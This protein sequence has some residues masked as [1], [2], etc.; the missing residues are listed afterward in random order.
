MKT[1][2]LVLL[3]L[4][5]AVNTSHALN[6]MTLVGQYEGEDPDDCFG[7]AMTMGDFDDDGY[8]EFII[9]AGGWNGYM[10]K[11]Y[12]YD[13]NGDWPTAPAWTFQGSA[14]HSE[15]DYDD[16]NVGDINGDG[17]D[18]FA[19]T[20]WIWQGARGVHFFY[21]GAD[22][23]SLPD[24]SMWSGDAPGLFG[25]LIDSCGDVNGDGGMDFIF[26][27]DWGG[28]NWDT[29]I[30]F[31]GQALDTIPDWI[32]P[33]TY[34]FPSGLGDVNGDG[35]ADIL[36]TGMNDEPPKLFF[37]GSPMDTI[38]DLIFPGIT[39]MEGSGVGDINGDDYNDFCISIWFPDSADGY[40]ELFFGGS[41]LDNIPEVI[42]QNRFGEPSGALFSLSCGD[43]N[44]DGYNDIVSA[45]GDQVFGVVVYIYLGS[46]SFNPVPDALVTDW[47]TFQGFG[48][49]VASGDVNGDSCDE[50]LVGAPQWPYYYDN[51]I[52]YLYT[53]PEEW[54]DYGAIVEPEE[55]VKYSG[56]FKLEQNFPNPFNSATSI[57]FE[58]GKASA[59]NLRI[60]DIAGDRIKN[61]IVNQNMLPGGYNVS[62][63]GKN[64]YD[65]PVASG[66]YLLELRVDSYHQITKMIV[67]R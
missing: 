1:L 32:Y 36:I 8:D 34:I 4:S 59:V 47:S 49:A 42:L 53:G 52:A 27:V 16:Q 67:L 17:L 15:Y 20:E 54:I 38:P 21:G 2:L 19:L 33:S 12:F 3:A 39:F 18:D 23:D 51:G 28:I 5:L 25:H 48:E 46:P 44:G 7:G 45:T 63:T 61:L 22:F 66:V 11:N 24:W 14:A 55:L 50:L 35:Y 37:G 41:D 31:G 43:F 60:Y 40:N 62:W 30:Y 10:G 26:R 57:H 9:G 64:E 56:A 29:R 58:L 13:W 65:Q 6:Q